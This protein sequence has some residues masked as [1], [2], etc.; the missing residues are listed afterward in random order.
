MHDTKIPLGPY[1]PLLKEPEHLRIY[2][3]GEEVVDTEF[4]LG[5]NHRG[6]EKLATTKTYDKNVHLLERI[7]GIC[8][9]AHNSAFTKAVERSTGLEA[10]E[11]AKYIRSIVGELERIQS[12]LLWFGTLSHSLGFDT[13]FM[14]SMTCREKALDLLE[15]ISGS[16]VHYGLSEFGGVKKD[17]GKETQKQIKDKI[18]K[19]KG[20]TEEMHEEIMSNNPYLERLEEVG[21]LPEKRARELG[22]VGPVAKGSGIERDTRK[23][24]EY[25]AYPLIDFKV[26]TRKKGDCLA[27]TQVRL[28]EI[29]EGVRIINQLL[30]LPKGEYRGEDTVQ[31][32]EDRIG[33]RAEAP[34]GENF[35]Y[36]HT[37]KRTPKRLRIRPPT[38]ANFTALPEMVTG[39]DIGDAPATVMSIDPCF[40][41]TDRACV[42]DTEE[43]EE[44]VKTFHEILGT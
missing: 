1:H 38:Y 12:H 11:R 36:L 37:G 21:E 6:I 16:R 35:H 17:I 8:S 25:D 4:F 34:R 28:E 5:Y 42:I 29:K 13:K 30:P 14:H 33:A 2:V 31:P 15:K 18:G 26:I 9:N 10:P 39:G 19:I 40:S 24:D 27:R 44:E 32:E 20:K 3:E 22:V 41:C 7:C 23:T 43:D